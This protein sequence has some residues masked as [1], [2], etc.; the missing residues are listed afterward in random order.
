MIKKC[1]NSS[2]PHYYSRRFEP[3][4]CEWFAYPL[5]AA[6]AV[7]T[8]EFR[9]ARVHWHVSCDYYNYLLSFYCL[10]FLVETD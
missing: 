2:I 7:N 6:P 8:K 5:T 1:A 4:V 10:V 9:L 3:D